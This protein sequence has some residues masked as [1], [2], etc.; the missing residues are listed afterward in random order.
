MKRFLRKGVVP[1]GGRVRYRDPDDGWECAHPYYGRVVM[2]A[3]EHRVEKNLP[4]P[5]NWEQ[6]VEDQI[7]RATDGACIEIDA[8]SAAKAAAELSP[9]WLKM[10]THFA[11]A[12]F[13][14]AASGFSVVSWDTF[15]ERMTQCRG[16]EEAG[17]PR[18][19]YYHPS[20]GGWS[21][22]HCGA[23]GCARQKLFLATERCPKGKW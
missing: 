3:H 12:M 16:D 11:G 4:I 7:C 2:L 15:K 13:K 22:V 17:V 19:Q 23:C 9:S 6:W 1:P 20:Q 14:W 18:C 10:A 21:L 5:H 8:E